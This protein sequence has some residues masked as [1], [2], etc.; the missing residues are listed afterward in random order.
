MRK[1]WLVLSGAL[2][3]L[4]ACGTSTPTAPTPSPSPVAVPSPTPVVTPVPFPTPTPEGEPPVTNTN[5][6]MRL[7]MRIFVIENPD[8]TYTGNVDPKL[9]IPVGYTARLDVTAKDIDNRETVGR[10]EVEFFF[11]DPGLA[12]ITGNHTNQ[13]RVQGL[14]IGSLDCWAV[15]DGVTSNT[16]TLTFVR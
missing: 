6:A 16:I 4:P 9:P 14:A 13:R 12:R 7:T 1:S 2:L 3:V 15:Q 8:G 10:S 5:P 11:S